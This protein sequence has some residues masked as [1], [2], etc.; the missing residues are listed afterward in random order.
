[1]ADRIKLVQGDTGPQVQLTLT[2]ETTGLAIDLTSATVTLHFRASGSDTV[3]FDRVCYVNPATASNGVAVVIWQSG[4]LNQE[5]G[6]YEGEIEIVFP[7]GMRQTVYDLLKFTI[8]GD[9]A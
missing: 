8:R 2:D 7:T 3:L 1:M 5:P 4:D 9:F 6:S